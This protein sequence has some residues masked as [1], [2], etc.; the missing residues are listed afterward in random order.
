MAVNLLLVLTLCYNERCVCFG[1]KCSPFGNLFWMI[2]CCYRCVVIR[3]IA[4]RNW[5]INLALS[6]VLCG[7]F[8]WVMKFRGVWWIYVASSTG[9]EQVFVVCGFWFTGTTKK[10]IYSDA[11]ALKCPCLIKGWLDGVVNWPFPPW[12]LSFRQNHTTLP[13]FGVEGVQ[14]TYFGILIIIASSYVHINIYR[15]NQ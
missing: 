9:C 10:S 13:I 5:E 15:L 11:V 3:M 1:G 12:G 6:L 7:G 8:Y 14:L 4:N 2:F